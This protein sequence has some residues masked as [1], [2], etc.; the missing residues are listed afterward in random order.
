MVLAEQDYIIPVELARAA[1]DRAGGPKK[2][3]VFPCGHFEVY[4]TEPWFSKA[5]N[6]MAEWYTK[7]L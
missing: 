4:I 7:Y 5:V 2:L 1:F 6:S 3:E